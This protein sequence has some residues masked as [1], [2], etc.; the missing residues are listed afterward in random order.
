M[1]RFILNSKP[2]EVRKNLV[3]DYLEHEKGLSVFI[4]STQTSIYTGC[5]ASDDTYLLVVVLMV[6]LDIGGGF[7]GGGGILA[8]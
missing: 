7:V 3:L 1:R 6:T 2:E 8:F 4:N 5:V